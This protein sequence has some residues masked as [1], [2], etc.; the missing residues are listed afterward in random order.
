MQCL[1]NYLSNVEG[2]SIKCINPWLIKI[3]ILYLIDDLLLSCLRLVFGWGFSKSSSED[4]RGAGF[5]FK[6]GSLLWPCIVGNVESMAEVFSE[7]E[8]SVVS[9]FSRGII[10]WCGSSRGDRLVAVGTKV[11][12]FFE[13]LCRPNDSLC[14]KSDSLDFFTFQ[15][16]TVFESSFKNDNK[17]SSSKLFLSS[18]F[19]SIAFCFVKSKGLFLV[20]L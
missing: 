8:C 18:C 16:G 20:W 2:W 5:G 17:G 6:S 7:L 19:S 14:N 12:F 9:L 15:G 11:T 13:V 10:E 3:L 4:R 1:C